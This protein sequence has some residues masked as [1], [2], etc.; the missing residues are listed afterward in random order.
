ML[1]NF[2]ASSELSPLTQSAVPMKRPGM[3]SDIFC[4]F[5]GLLYCLGGRDHPDHDENTVFGESD[6]ISLFELCVKQKVTDR[7]T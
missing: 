6:I 4:S 5:S 3:I 7:D 1:P 2:K